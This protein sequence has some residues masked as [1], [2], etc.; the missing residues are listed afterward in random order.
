MP[1]RRTTRPFAEEL[2]A[3]LAERK[4]SLRALAREMDIGPDHL[5]RVVSGAR[6]KRP[7]ADLVRRTSNALGLPEDYFLEA[8]LAIVI[9]R[10]EEDPALVDRIYARIKR[11]S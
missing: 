4:L 6:G 5:S 1:K 9:E 2:P 11:Q 8:R 3:L 10:L 7:T